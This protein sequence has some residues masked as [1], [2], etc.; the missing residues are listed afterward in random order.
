MTEAK[1]PAKPPPGFSAFKALLKKIVKVPKEELDERE[2]EY[3]RTRGRKRQRAAGG[4]DRTKRMELGLL[5]F[6]IS[7]PCL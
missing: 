3:Q 5:G 6:E 4:V 1:P 7:K 2:E